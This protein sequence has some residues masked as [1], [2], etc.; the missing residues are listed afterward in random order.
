MKLKTRN[1]WQILL[2]SIVILSACNRYVDVVK[3]GS[4]MPIQ[5]GYLNFYRDSNVLI[6]KSNIILTRDTEK[7]YPRSFEVTLPKRIKYYEFLGMSDFAFYYDQNQVFFIKINLENRKGISDSSYVP[8]TEGLANFIQQL[9]TGNNKKYN[10]HEIAVNA[11][12]VNKIVTKGD[13]TI[14]LY[15]IKKENEDIFS[16]YL[17]SFVFLNQ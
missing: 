13:A 17:S 12:R 4:N 11:D 1:I 16:S 6:Y 5:Q 9:S 14:L 15:N 3:N 2:L 8:S 7:I 10:I